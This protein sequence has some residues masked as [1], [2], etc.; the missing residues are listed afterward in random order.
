MPPKQMHFLNCTP[1]FSDEN[2]SVADLFPHYPLKM[3]AVYGLSLPLQIR[4]TYW[5]KTHRVPLQSHTHTSYIQLYL[6]VYYTYKML[7]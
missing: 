3:V 6:F 7:E 5:L 2:P 4:N 1:N